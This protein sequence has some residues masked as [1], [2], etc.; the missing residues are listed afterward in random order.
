MK[1]QES[2]SSP[3]IALPDRF[4]CLLAKIVSGG[5]SGVDRAAL[6]WAIRRGFP[7]GGWCPRGRRAEDGT[8]DDRYGLRETESAGYRQRTRQNVIDSDGTLILNMGELS[9]GSLTTLQFAER[10]DKPYLVIQLEAG[11]EGITRTWEWLGAKRITTLNVAGPRESKRP[12]IYQACFAFL[13]RL[14]ECQ[15]C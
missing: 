7:H 1:K 12:G 10:F 14:A 2:F 4:A 5:Q 6:D 15:S 13:E 3:A 8:I 9:D 11:S